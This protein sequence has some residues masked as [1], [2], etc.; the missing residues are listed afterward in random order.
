MLHLRQRLDQPPDRTLGR[1]GVG[2]VNGNMLV[3]AGQSPLENGFSV[4]IPSS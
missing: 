2:P 4:F 1:P 3:T